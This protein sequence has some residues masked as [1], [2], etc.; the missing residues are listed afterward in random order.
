MNT[1]EYHDFIDALLDDK[2]TP[3][4]LLKLK[5]LHEIMS[6][7]I[8]ATTIAVAPFAWVGNRWLQGKIVTL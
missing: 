7:N 8:L 6:I 5:R 1:W 4:G 3:A 2:L